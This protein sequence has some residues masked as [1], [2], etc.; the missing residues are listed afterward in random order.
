MIFRMTSSGTG[1]PAAMPVLRPPL[2]QRWL[3]IALAKGNA[4]QAREV[5]IN[6]RESFKM[7]AGIVPVQGRQFGDEHCCDAMTAAPSAASN[8]G[9]H[10]ATHR[11][12]HR[13]SATARSVATGSKP[14]LEASRNVSI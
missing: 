11:T 1:D 8:Q 12:V 6:V 9:G 3:R 10:K 5:E 7:F 14:S 4:P 13:S 2:R